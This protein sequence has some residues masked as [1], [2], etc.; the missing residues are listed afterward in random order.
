[1]LD[2][3]EDYLASSHYPF[4]RIDGDT[5]HKDRQAAIDRFMANKKSKTPGNSRATS[6][7]GEQEA[8]S[9]AGNARK[10]ERSG[11]P[12]A[13]LPSATDGSKS[14]EQSL[15]QAAGVGDT[16]LPEG[17]FVFLLST[18]AGGQG[19]TLTS[20]NT[21]IIYDSDWNPQ[22]RCSQLFCMTR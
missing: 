6:P 14:A 7:A 3:L 17:P 19:I 1:M 22:V 13:Q 5:K 18:R 15:G 12:S 16:V 11:P 10:Q 21:I 2:V 9:S 8:W 4:E 20:A